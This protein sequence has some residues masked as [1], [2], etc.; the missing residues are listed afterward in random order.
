VQRGQDA[1]GQQHAAATE[2]SDEIQGRQWPLPLA[3]N[4][5]ER[6][7][8]GDVV[9]VVPGATRQRTV[10]AVTRHAREDQ[11]WVLGKQCLGA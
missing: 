3:S 11:F 4:G 8:D 7:S 2:V 10:L 6:A 9:D 5:F 1:D